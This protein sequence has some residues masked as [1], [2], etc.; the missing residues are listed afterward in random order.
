[1]FQALLLVLPHRST[2]EVATFPSSSS[3]MTTTLGLSAGTRNC[4]ESRGAGCCCCCCCCCCI[5]ADALPPP[6]V[7]P[8]SSSSSSSSTTTG[9]VMCAETRVACRGCCRAPAKAVTPGAVAPRP[10]SSTTTGD[11]VEA[12][13]VGRCCC[14]CCCCVFLRLGVCAGSDGLCNGSPAC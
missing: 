4:V 12:W 8:L 5:L 3:I 6:A 1:M 13:V 7:A 10:S 14:C 9:T 2:Q 11:G